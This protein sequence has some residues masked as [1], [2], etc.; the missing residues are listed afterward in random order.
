MR[1]AMQAV[2]LAGATGADPGR[3][4]VTALRALEGIWRHGYRYKK[5]G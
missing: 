1:H 4:I 2:P 5:A 3:L